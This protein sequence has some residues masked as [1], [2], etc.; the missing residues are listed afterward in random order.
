M[1][2]RSAFIGSAG[3]GK[4]SAAARADFAEAAVAV[5]TSAG[6]EG[7]IY[8][9]AG[10]ESFTL[11]DL[12][13]EISRQTGKDIPYKNLPEADYA[14][15]LTSFGLPDGLAKAIAGWD[16]A[17]SNGALFD[18]GR[19]LSAL[20]GRPTTPLSEVVATALKGV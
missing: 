3:G 19:Q 8:E 9:L 11:T 13:A 15:L 7:K 16:V 17:A 12:A 4:I 10:D 14:A 5:L 6:H 18:E 20:I 2:F 1:L